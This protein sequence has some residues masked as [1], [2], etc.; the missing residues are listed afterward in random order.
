MMRLTPIVRN[1]IIANVAVFF[2]LNIVINL[3]VGE[4]VIRFFSD[5]FLLFKSDAIMARDGNAFHPVQ[6]VTHFFSHIQLW[7]IAF[8][9][10]ALAS[11]GPAVEMVWGSKRFLTFYLF[12]GTVGGLM[13][14][15]LDPSPNPVLGA[16][17]AISGVVAAFAVNFP[18]TKLSLFFLPGIEARYL[19]IGIGVLSAVLVF[20]RYREVDT[21]SI[22][23]FGHLA[24]MVAAVIYFYIE[25][26]L[27]I[28]RE[29]R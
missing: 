1:I 14:A 19:A 8:N 26:F 24:G 23:H 16:S 7:H 10:F 15:F 12:T 3:N 9:M 27:P 4:G 28:G 6:L 20:A 18:R 22:S 11:L 2:I 25:R 17:G 5:Y 29:K 13:I 21:G